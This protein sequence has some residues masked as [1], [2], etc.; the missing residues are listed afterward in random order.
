MITGGQKGYELLRQLGIG[1]KEGV[2]E[3]KQDE[4]IRTQRASGMVIVTVIEGGSKRPSQEVS[5]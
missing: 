3:M 1:F 5:G 4:F 2:F